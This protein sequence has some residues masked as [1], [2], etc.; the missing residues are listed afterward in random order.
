MP[1]K[2]GKYGIKIWSLC[3]AKIFYLCNFDV[4]LAKIAN[5]AEKQQGQVVWQLCSFWKNTE[6]VVTTDNFFTDISLAEE[7]LTNKIYTVRTIRKNKKDLPKVLYEIKDRQKFSSQFLFTNDLSPTTLIVM[8]LSEEA[9]ASI[10]PH[11][12]FV[13]KIFRVL[14]SYLKFGDLI[15]EHP[16]DFSTHTT[17]FLI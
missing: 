6:R 5:T 17:T 12:K 10:L 9:F 7:L 13:P 1:N 16:V 4:Y 11:K 14:N 15:R 3:D 8:Y 2:P